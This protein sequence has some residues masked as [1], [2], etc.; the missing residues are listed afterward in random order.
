LRK[1]IIAIIFVTLLLTLS[2]S[3]IV[4]ANADID[5]VLTEEEYE[6]FEN[7]KE[8]GERLYESLIRILGNDSGY[9]FCG[10]AYVNS[11]GMGLHLGRGF[12]Y[13]LI[14]IPVRISIPSFARFPRPMFQQWFIFTQYFYDEKA[15]TNITP[16][17][18]DDPISLKGDHSVFA[19][20]YMFNLP[21]RM[22]KTINNVLKTLN[23][24]QINFPILDAH[25]RMFWYFDLT[26]NT[27]N[28]LLNTAISG[29]KFVVLLSFVFAWALFWPFHIK[30]QFLG[31]V[32]PVN[33]RGYSPFVIWKE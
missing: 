23:L 9:K 8:L 3:G 22:R 21:N 2:F 15:V 7:Q 20:V 16:L 29:V 27:G 24:K 17:N 31:F 11:T 14:S 1:K 10:P 4:N 6:F 30:S 18:G 12:R 26:A 28:Q 13:I 19:G 25:G 32:K 33:W 5:E